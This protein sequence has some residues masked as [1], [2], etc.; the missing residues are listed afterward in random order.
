[1][2]GKSSQCKHLTTAC[3]RHHLANWKDKQ[4]FVLLNNRSVF[5]VFLFSFIYPCIQIK[6][7]I[8]IIARNIQV[9]YHM[10]S[11]YIVPSHDLSSDMQHMHHASL[12]ID[13][14]LLET[15]YVL[16]WRSHRLWAH[17]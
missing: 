14:A 3:S 17:A 10:N 12:H 16:A 6:E 7:N 11:G 9:M 2:V 5:V 15:R 1:M 8:Q 13:S 4:G